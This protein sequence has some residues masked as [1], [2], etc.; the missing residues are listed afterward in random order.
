MDREKTPPALTQHLL[1][2]EHSNRSNE[3]KFEAHELPV[4]QCG[5]HQE[6]A[7]HPIMDVVIIR[8]TNFLDPGVGRAIRQIEI[9]PFQDIWL[10]GQDVLPR[11]AIVRHVDK[12]TN[13]R[14]MLLLILCCNKHSG[15]SKE[16]IIIFVHVAL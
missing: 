8:F 15:D 16:F 11:V 6:L 1:S 3:A 14:D 7:E 5:L 13:R 2:C 4:E 12:V 9:E 10:C